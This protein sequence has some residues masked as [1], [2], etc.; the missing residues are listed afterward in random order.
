M[1]PH[2]QI[3]LTWAARLAGLLA[4]L[5]LAVFA[6]DAFDGRPLAE[7]IPAF[8]IHLG[9]AAAVGLVVAAGWRHPWIGAAGFALL[10]VAYAAWVPDRP[11]WILV[12]SGPLA[13]TALLFALS[14]RAGRRGA[15]QSGSGLAS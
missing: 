3:I 4:T 2:A 1:S 13:A 8:V 9:P 15:V 6:L 10:A 11:D 5:F 12:I 14:A 7:A